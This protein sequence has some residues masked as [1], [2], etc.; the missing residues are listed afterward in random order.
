YVADSSRVKCNYCKCTYSACKGKGSTSN[1]SAHLQKN[2]SGKFNSEK[3]PS[4]SLIS[5]LQT[6]NEIFDN[7][8]FRKLL[9]KWIVTSN[10]PFLEV[11]N[12]DFRDLIFYLNKNAE[13]IGADTIRRDLLVTYNDM[14]FIKK[15]QFES[16]P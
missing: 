16:L 15:K 5:Y 14:K 2:H 6:K 11:E 12:S 8:K 1:M 3:D 10:Q 9:L 13:T 4:G 7:K